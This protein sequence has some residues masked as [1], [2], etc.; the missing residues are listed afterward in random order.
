MSLPAMT[1]EGRATILEQKVVDGLK[2]RLRGD[3]LRPGE[4]R[5]EVA[6]KIWNAMIER[7]PAL[8]GRCVIPADVIQCVNFAREHDL[9]VS[10]CSARG[11]TCSG[12]VRRRGTHH[13]QR[14]DAGRAARDVLAPGD[15]RK[16]SRSVA[17]SQRRVSVA[18]PATA[19]FHGGQPRGKSP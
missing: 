14:T 5:Y 6:R 3:L 4:D 16:A 7:R 15:R 12:G 2:A 9:L 19:Q 13:R 10:V 8:I 1:T 17:R 11:W 18:V